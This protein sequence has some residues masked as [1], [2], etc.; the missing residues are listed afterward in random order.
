MLVTQSCPILRDPMDFSPPR[1]SVHEI[2]QARILE[3]VAMSFSRGFSQPRDWTRVSCI[4]GRFFSNWATREVYTVEVTNR[5]KG[6]GLIDKVCE[7]LWMVVHDIVEE[8]EIKTI[9]KKKKC[10]KAKWLIIGN[11]GKHLGKCCRR[12][13]LINYICL[14]KELHIHI[15]QKICNPSS[16][17]R[18]IQHILIKYKCRYRLFSFQFSK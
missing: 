1:S 10:K 11:Y 3:W 6:F 14:G 5:F 8:A 9:S 17:K 7:E 4:A 13:W 12:S 2:F 15:I 18:L 16:Q